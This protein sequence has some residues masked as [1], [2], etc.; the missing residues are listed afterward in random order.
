LHCPTAA[1]VKAPTQRERAANLHRVLIG[2]SGM[3][4]MIG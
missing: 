2:F 4:K 1:R 3:R